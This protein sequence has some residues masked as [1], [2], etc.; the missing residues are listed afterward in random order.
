MMSKKS[1]MS[2]ILW[3]AAV[4]K[5]FWDRYSDISKYGETGEVA[6]KWEKEVR[7]FKKIYLSCE[8]VSRGKVQW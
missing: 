8:N 5:L 6:S 2:K 1:K 4:G 3:T 7:I